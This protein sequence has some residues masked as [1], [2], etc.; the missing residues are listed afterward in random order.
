MVGESG[1]INFKHLNLFPGPAFSTE[2]VMY[3]K[4]GRS[5]DPTLLTSSKVI[6]A[7]GNSSD[8]IAA[9]IFRVR[10]KANYSLWME[11]YAK[12]FDDNTIEVQ[13]DRLRPIR[14]NL[15]VRSGTPLWNLLFFKVCV[16]PKRLT[17]ILQVKL[18]SFTIVLCGTNFGG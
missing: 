5:R 8:L 16:I 9:Y 13:V 1:T 15:K 12:T 7:N 3:R 17:N 11:G 10:K 14:W 2:T 4:D 6:K 18:T